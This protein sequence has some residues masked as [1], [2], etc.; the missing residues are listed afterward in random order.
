VAVRPYRYSVALKDKLERQCATMIEQRFVRHSDSP[1]SL[2]VLLVKKFDSSWCFC[3]DY[4]AL[5]AMTIKDAFSI[6]VVDELLDE[7]HDAKFF[8]KLDL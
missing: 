1:F 8:S 2:P 6:P 3:I 5:N 4:W 7:L